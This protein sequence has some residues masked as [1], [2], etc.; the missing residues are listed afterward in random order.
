MVE[1]ERE[2]QDWKRDIGNLRNEVRFL[3]DELRLKI[4]LAGMEAKDAWNKVEPR[5]HDFEQR[6]ENAAQTTSTEVRA[7]AK[8]LK[9]HLQK[10]RDSL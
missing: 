6:A 3:A 5:L 4:H 9:A 2:T 8:D 1:P 7:M 10:I